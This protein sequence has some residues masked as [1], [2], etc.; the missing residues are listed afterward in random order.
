V[1]NPGNYDERGRAKSGRAWTKPRRQKRTEHRVRLLHERVAN[2]RRAQAH[3]LTTALTRE[4]GVIGVE[5]LAVRNLMANRRL[6]R[7]IADVGWGTILNQLAYKTVWAGSTLVAADRFYPSSK[8]CSQCGTVKAKLSLSERVF[9]CEV[10]GHEQDRDL[11]AAANLARM[12]QHYAQAEGLQ[13]LVAAA[14]AETLNA[15]GG[16]VRPA[17]WSRQRPLKREDP[18]GSSQRR[19]TPVSPAPESPR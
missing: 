10:C 15:R 12:A 19:K 11:N 5:T 9:A 14:G 4:F 7:H 17:P 1:N 6:A 8:T 3:Q 13:C 18:S 2:L 16:H